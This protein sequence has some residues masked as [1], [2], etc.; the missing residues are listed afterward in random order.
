MKVLIVTCKF[1]MGHY[2]AAEN[3]A[4]KISQSDLDATST[5]IDISQI[6]L[7]KASEW[8]YYLYKTLVSKTSWAYNRVYKNALD[9]SG[10][11][12]K[13]LKAPEKYVLK[14]L[15]K[16]IKQHQPDAII[17]TYSLASHFLAEYK[18]AGGM[19][20]P[21]VT[22]VTD[23]SAHNVWINEDTDYYLV[24]TQQTKREL[25]ARGVEAE[26]IGV[27]GI[28]VSHEYEQ[29]IQHSL[30]ETRN[31]QNDVKE[32]LIMGGGLGLLPT[33]ME[34]YRELDR[35]PNIHSTIICGQN[36]KL[37]SRLQKEKF[38]NIEVLG[39]CQNVSEHMKDADILI[40]KPGGLTTFEAIYAEVPLL[41][42]APYLQQEKTNAAYIASQKMGCILPKKTEDILAVL[43]EV[44]GNGELLKSY[45]LN[46]RQTRQCLAKTALIEFLHK[47]ER[48][49]CMS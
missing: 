25:I 6:V 24:A 33:N 46:M 26:K 12:E 28:P 10:K 21:L 19:R 22:C 17:S 7:G 31:K 35:L 4:K 30:C 2:I 9:S 41:S 43:Q 20:I 5:V 45:R 49:V 39:F 18:R 14:K 37:C 29:G 3:L 8:F 42:F 48:R 15:E 13:L 1:G 40:S 16:E 11:M 44:A 27:S 38:E 23:L 32:M 34:F 36:E 47:T